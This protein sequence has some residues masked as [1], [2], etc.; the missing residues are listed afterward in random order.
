MK[1]KKEGRKIGRKKRKI[2]ESK[3]NRYNMVKKESV[4]IFKEGVE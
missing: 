2:R 4:R 1:R 3:Y